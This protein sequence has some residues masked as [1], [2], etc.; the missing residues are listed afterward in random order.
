MKLQ[1]VF[2]GYEP[3]SVD[4]ENG[5][6]AVFERLT[7]TEASSALEDAAM[8]DEDETGWIAAEIG[9][10]HCCLKICG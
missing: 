8:A 7:A 4:T 3:V 6:C 5:T 10:E 1:V 9:G 2:A